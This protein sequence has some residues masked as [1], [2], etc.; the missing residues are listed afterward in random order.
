[1]FLKRKSKTTMYMRKKAQ[2]GGGERVWIVWH[3]ERS[4][5]GDKEG[6]F[7]V[8]KWSLFFSFVCVKCSFCFLCG[9]CRMRWS[10]SWSQCYQPQTHSNTGPGSEVGGGDK[11]WDG[12]DGGLRVIRNGMEPVIC[13][14][15][16]LDTKLDQYNRGNTMSQINVEFRDLSWVQTCDSPLWILY[17][18]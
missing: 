1:M 14:E 9:N 2:A 12:A 16:D 4:R 5:V 8:C 3:S 10:D 13:T 17:F 11:D 7:V 6:F 15:F 18:L